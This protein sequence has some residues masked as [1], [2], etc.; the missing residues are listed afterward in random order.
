MYQTLLVSDREEVLFDLERLEIWG[1][2][3]GF[4]I[5]GTVGG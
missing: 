3:S 4:E 1:D 2:K 5:A